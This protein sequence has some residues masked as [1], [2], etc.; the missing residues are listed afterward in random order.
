[1][2]PPMLGVFISYY[3]LIPY[4]LFSEYRRRWEYQQAN[5]ILSEVEKMKSNFLSLI[6]HDLKTPVARIQGLAES[7]LQEKAGRLDTEDKKP[8][9]A[10]IKNS[11]DLNDFITRILDISRMETSEVKLNLTSRD[12]NALIEEISGRFHYIMKDKDITLEKDLEPLFSIKVDDQL[13]GQ[14]IY[15]LLDNAIKYSDRGKKIFI[16]SWEEDDYVKVSVRDQGIGIE[17]EKIKNMFTKF[18]RIKDSRKQDVK[19]TGLGLYLVKYFI[20]LHGGIITVDSKLDEGT[21]FTFMI[22]VK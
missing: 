21:V 3:L 15:N 9:K 8:I 1:M 5:K 10:I 2:V 19:G 7:F 16:K 22:P 13:I 6:T 20:E 18:Y 17:P 11:V 12:I 14:V 4:R